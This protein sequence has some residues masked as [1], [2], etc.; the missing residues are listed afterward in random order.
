M[1][2]L[3][4]AAEACSAW[5]S[6]SILSRGGWRLTSFLFWW[7]GAAVVNQPPAAPGFGPLGVHPKAFPQ[8]R[9]TPLAI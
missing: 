2:Y 9:R 6:A 8:G 1:A 4:H 5:P 3:G 7:R